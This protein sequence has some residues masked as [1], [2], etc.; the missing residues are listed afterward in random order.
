[1]I[2]PAPPMITEEFPRRL[3]KEFRDHEDPGR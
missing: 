1:M 2:T 3:R